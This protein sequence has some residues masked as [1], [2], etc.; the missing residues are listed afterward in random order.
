LYN[1]AAL[2]YYL[3]GTGNHDACAA[4]QGDSHVAQRSGNELIAQ[5]RPTCARKERHMASTTTPAQ[6]PLLP[7]ARVTLPIL[8]LGGYATLLVTGYDTP[9]G[10]LHAL[11]LYGYLCLLLLILQIAISPTQS[12]ARLLYV[13][14]SSA[15]AIVY[16]GERAFGPQTNGNFTKSPYTYIIIN[17]LLLIVFLV[18]VIMRRRG[19][20]KV[21]AAATGTRAPSTGYGTLATDFAGLAIL[22]YLSWFVLDLLGPQTILHAFNL[23]SSTPYVTVDL[24]Q[25]LGLSNLPGNITLLQDLDLVLGYGATAVTLLLL[26]LVGVLTVAGGQSATPSSTQAPEGSTATFGGNLLAVI[27]AAANEVLLSLRLVLGPLVWL[28]PALSMT[29]LAQGVTKYLDASAQASSGSVLDLFNPVSTASVQNIPTGFTNVGLGLLAVAAVI[30]SVAVVEHDAAILRRTL[31]IFLVGG[32]TVAVTLAFF[33]YSLAALNAFI[34]TLSSNKT[35]P[36]QVGAAG[37]LALLVSGGLV[38]A[39]ARR[40]GGKVQTPTPVG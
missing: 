21:A 33:L 3:S 9:L 27:V 37:L 17:G 28:I 26:G 38:A 7:P 2:S 24:K 36:F 22:F 25:A 4:Q 11:P 18:D 10:T 39:A 16:A 23:G 35:E 12:V 1:S 29:A 31:G 34:I 30:V 20:S 13:F 32:R 6:T 15:F 40:Q 14:V 5:V 19:Q 8:V